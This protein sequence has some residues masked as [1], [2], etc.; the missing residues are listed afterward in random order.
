M[1]PPFGGRHIQFFFGFFSFIEKSY[2]DWWLTDPIKKTISSPLLGRIRK[3][4][5]NKESLTEKHSILFQD[6][7]L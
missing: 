6:G 1:S 5:S 2:Q 4:L 7:V 3:K